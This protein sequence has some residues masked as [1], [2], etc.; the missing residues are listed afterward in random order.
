MLQSEFE[1]RVGMRVTPEEYSHIEVVY[2]NSDVDKDEFCK[3]WAKMNQSRIKVSK[4]RAKEQEELDKFRTRLWKIVEK[5]APK[6]WY[7]KETTWADMAMTVTEIK[8]IQKSGIQLTDNCRPK[9]LSTV[10]WEIKKYLK[11]A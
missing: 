8:L 2:M 7:F 9:F 5:Y 10:I 11:A 6:D 4:Q 1:T 3:M